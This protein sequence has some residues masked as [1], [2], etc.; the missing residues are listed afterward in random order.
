VPRFCVGLPRNR[1]LIQLKGKTFSSNIQGVYGVPS[2]W[3][4][5]PDVKLIAHLRARP[6][7]SITITTN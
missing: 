3:T 1:N 4:K 2:P 7:W 5:L 6:R